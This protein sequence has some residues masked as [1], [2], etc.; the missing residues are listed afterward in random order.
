MHPS[1]TGDQRR[2]VPR[3]S[4]LA[5]ALAIAAIAFGACTSGTVSTPAPT[6]GS[7]AAPTA[8]T[9]VAPSATAA[10]TDAAS[11]SA[12]GSTAPSGP[13]AKVGL[14]LS[15]IPSVQFFPPLLAKGL[16]YFAEEGLDVD[17]QPSEGSSFVVQQVA[18]GNVQSGLPAS[19]ATILGFRQSPNFKVVYQFANQSF[20]IYVLDDSP[21][22]TV[23]DLKGR[24]AGA[25]DLAGGEMLSLRIALEQANLTAQQDV[26]VEALGY[27]E[28][29][30][31]EALQN[32][33]VD[34]LS[35]YWSTSAIAQHAGIKLRCITCGGTP[36][37]GMGLIVA[38]SYLAANQQAIVG[39]GRAMAK[40]TLFAQTNPDA[41]VAVLQKV[42]PEGSTDVGQLKDSLAVAVQA[43][44]PAAGAQYG[45]N[46]SA[47]WQALMQGM[48]KPG[49]QSGLDQAIDVNQLVDNSL[50]AQF[51]D[52]DHDAV[53]N[54][55]RTYQP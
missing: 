33:R 44:A 7:S 13:A 29:G 14:M 12:A 19:Q 11:T 27:N 39:I 6:T 18:A 1:S 46:D 31:A 16:G 17:I 43:I 4:R 25:P 51:N 3:L 22:K 15:Y 32:H 42:N 55:A 50:V 30:M 2:R 24:T 54:Q 10:A 53:V 36:D 5:G 48:L 26:K 9:S 52:F 21:I 41:A 49:A 47:A 34:A 38:N 45:A 8:A 40:A 20:G 28:L 37:V 35:I 23:A